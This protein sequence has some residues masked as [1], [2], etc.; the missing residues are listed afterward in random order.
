MD[1]PR[2][3]PESLEP[4]PPWMLRIEFLAQKIVKGR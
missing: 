1:L 2:G 3:W 4:L